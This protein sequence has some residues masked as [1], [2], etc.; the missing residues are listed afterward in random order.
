MGKYSKKPERSPKKVLIILLTIILV[1]AIAI[2]LGIWGAKHFQPED[3]SNPTETTEPSVSEET[4]LPQE[5]IDDVQQEDTQEVISGLQIDRIDSY[6]GI[7]MEDG[8]DEFVSD[9]MMMIVKNTTSDDLQLARIYVHYAD[10]VAEFEVTNLPSQA[11]VV[12]LEK[13]RHQMVEQE[14]AMISVENVLFFSKDMSLMKDTF[15]I[16]GGNGYLDVTN[17]SDQATAGTVYIYYKNSAKDLLYG[18]ITYRAKVE[19]SIAPGETIRIMT[20]HYQA[21][22]CRLVMVTCDQ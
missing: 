7:Y 22:L 2:P 19:E 12:L 18:G 17:I 9:V 11:S 8:S 10:F 4:E 15:Q 13:N 3:S 21:D 14:H 6:A 5:T 20:K 1:L 16:S